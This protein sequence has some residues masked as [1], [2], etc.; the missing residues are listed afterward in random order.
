M[1]TKKYARQNNP[2][3]PIVFLSGPMRGVPRSASLAWRELARKMLGDDFV[4]LHALRGR[5]K[6][7]T[8]PDPR[9]AVV[10][11]KQDIRRCKIVLVNDTFKDC[12]MIGTAME[13]FLAYSLDKPV[14]V[15]GHAH[16]DD[17]WLNA[18]S[19]MRVGSLK[20]A[21]EIIRYFFRE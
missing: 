5:E 19:H 20:E 8:F 6:K 11:D 16:I 3:R 17:Y 21:C 13:V 12:S 4:V 18:H 7:E 14:I 1:P 9:G 15:F 2:D 10:R